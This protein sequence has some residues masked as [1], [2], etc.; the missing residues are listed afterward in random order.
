[1]NKNPRS[2]ASSAGA[3][4]VMSKK[5]CHNGNPL[6][7]AAWCCFAR[8]CRRYNG[9][10]GDG[11]GGRWRRPMAS[12]WMSTSTS[13]GHGHGS[14]MAYHCPVC[15]FR[16]CDLCFLSHNPQS[17]VVIYPRQQLQLIELMWLPCELQLRSRKRQWSPVVTREPPVRSSST[18]G[19][20]FVVQVSQLFLR[21]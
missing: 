14:M 16:R 6:H 19:A 13:Y 11:V 3:L 1:M 12:R 10:R 2:R 9:S 7:K 4:W 17:P 20:N 15:F 8:L 21:L 5:G 18:A